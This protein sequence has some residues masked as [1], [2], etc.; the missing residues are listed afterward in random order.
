MILGDYYS[1][2]FFRAA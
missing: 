1:S 2:I